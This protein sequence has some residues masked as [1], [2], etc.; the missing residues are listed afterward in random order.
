MARKRKHHTMVDFCVDMNPEDVLTMLNDHY[1]EFVKAYEPASKIA[2]NGDFIRFV[3]EQG[4]LK[5]KMNKGM[6]A[7][8]FSGYVEDDPN[9]TSIRLQ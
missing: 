2:D 5:I 8:N 4:S 1:P 3:E 6:D 9:Y 7:S